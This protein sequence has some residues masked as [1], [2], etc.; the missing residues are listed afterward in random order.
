MKQTVAE[1]VKVL[2]NLLQNTM[3]VKK[4]L[5]GDII[6]TFVS[7]LIHEEAR[8]L[9]SSDDDTPVDLVSA[10]HGFLLLAAR[11]TSVCVPSDV[12]LTQLPKLIAEAKST[13]Q[14]F[15]LIL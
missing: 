8:R 13:S 9:N 1:A 4:I 2:S 15:L 11:H 6:D 5:E 7:I 12:F 3:A 10:V 14:V